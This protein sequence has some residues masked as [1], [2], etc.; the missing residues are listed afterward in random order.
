MRRDAY[1]GKS[2]QELLELQR[3][4]EEDPASQSAGGLY[5]YTPAARV[6]LDALRLQIVAN[7]AEKRAAEGRPVPCNGYSGRKS[8]KRR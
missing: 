7:M 4:I 3:R 1:A 8:N 2:T 5:L 6:K